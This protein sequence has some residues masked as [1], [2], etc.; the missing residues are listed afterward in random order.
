MD[1]RT[2]SINKEY[3]RCPVLALSYLWRLHHSVLHEL[4]YPICVQAQTASVRLQMDSVRTE[5]AHV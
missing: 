3:S 4:F 2:Y 5:T 1:R